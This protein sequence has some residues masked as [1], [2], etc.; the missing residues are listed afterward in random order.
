[1]PIDRSKLINMEAMSK[2]AWCEAWNNLQSWKDDILAPDG[3]DDQY[4]SLD[5]FPEV[6]EALV[7]LNMTVDRA[8]GELRR[9]APSEVKQKIDDALAELKKED[10]RPVRRVRRAFIR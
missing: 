2:R 5:A 8:L 10:S 3:R 1:M 4:P 9:E 6:K 7:N